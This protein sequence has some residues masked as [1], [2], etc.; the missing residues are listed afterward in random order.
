MALE[1]APGQRR[2]HPTS[3]YKT[4]PAD[5]AFRSVGFL[6]ESISEDLPFDRKRG[7]LLNNQGRV[8]DQPG[9]YCSGW[10]KNG[11][12]GIIATTMS[13]A[14]STANV[15]LADLDALSRCRRTASLICKDFPPR[16]QSIACFI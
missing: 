4:L 13:D 10:I 1:G 12:V 2:P 16:D 5:V 7:V 6:G 15:V 9:L 8:Q 11:P 3:Q 14:Q